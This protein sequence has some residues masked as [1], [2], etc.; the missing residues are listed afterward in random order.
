MLCFSGAV[1]R[2]PTEAGLRCAL[3]RLDLLLLLDDVSAFP[4]KP[5]SCGASV[6]P[7]WGD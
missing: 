2:V 6:R 7:A 5:E 1:H 3:V 4:E